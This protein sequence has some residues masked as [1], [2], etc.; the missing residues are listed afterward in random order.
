MSDNDFNLTK[1]NYPDAIVEIPMNEKEWMQY[2]SSEV[3]KSYIKAEKLKTLCEQLGLDV[4]LPTSFD[5]RTASLGNIATEG[6]LM[7]PE[8]YGGGLRDV[9][10][11]AWTYRRDVG[12][13]E[14][15]IFSKLNE[16]AKT[17]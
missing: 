4:P 5:Q 2:L 13:Y 15:E 7:N 12:S 1:T 11:K 16:N 14:E 17:R 9:I 10:R 8:S 3:H 6:R